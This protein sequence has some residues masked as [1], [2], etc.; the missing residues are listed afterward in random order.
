[1][2]TSACLALPRV[3][4]SRLCDRLPLEIGDGIESAAR[5]RLY[6]VFAK[7]GTRAT[8]SPRRRA[9]MLALKFARDLAGSV[10]AR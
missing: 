10:L 2:L 6:M 9:R 8:H 1:M 5:E 3:F 4:R 7:T